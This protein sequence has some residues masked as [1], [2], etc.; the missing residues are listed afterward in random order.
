MTDDPHPDFARESFTRRGVTHEILRS[1][2][3]PAVIV[4]A[5]IP[6]VT[7][8]V[9]DLARQ[10]RDLGCTVVLPVLFGR[11]GHDAHPDSAGRLG[12]AAE[13]EGPQWDGSVLWLDDIEIAPR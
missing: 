1:G 5:E 12:S 4:V 10:V 13:Y 9:L 6:G 11:L 2:S 8:R 3:G 7:P